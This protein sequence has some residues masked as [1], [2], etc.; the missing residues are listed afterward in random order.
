MDLVPIWLWHT[1]GAHD[2]LQ[3]ELGDFRQRCCSCNLLL[4]DDTLTHQTDAFGALARFLQLWLDELDKL[5]KRP[6]ETFLPFDFADQGSCWLR[7]YS[8]DNIEAT[9]VAGIRSI[10]GISLKAS[11]FVRYARE[12]FDPWTAWAL[13]C[14]LDGLIRTLVENRYALN[15]RSEQPVEFSSRRHRRWRLSLV[16]RR[17]RRR[18]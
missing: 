9:V 18:R 4:L 16:T 7:V 15:S 11:D 2:D 17:R 3:L 14:D 8:G 6:G 5:C 13:T 10:D 1:P 12:Y